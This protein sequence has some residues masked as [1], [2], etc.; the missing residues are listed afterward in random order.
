[1]VV[2]GSGIFYFSIKE[3]NIAALR[4]EKKGGSLRLRRKKKRKV[5]FVGN[6]RVAAKITIKK[7]NGSQQNRNVSNSHKNNKI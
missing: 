3:K 7:R 5:G 1:L 4:Q 2:E 6:L